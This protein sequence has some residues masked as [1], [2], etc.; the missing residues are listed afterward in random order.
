MFLAYFLRSD[1]VEFLNNAKKNFR[2]CVNVETMHLGMTYKAFLQVFHP[3]YK[4]NRM[5]S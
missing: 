3:I 4:A 1:L 5:V 2:M